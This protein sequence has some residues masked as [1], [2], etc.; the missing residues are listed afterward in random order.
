MESKENLAMHWGGP[1]K[2]QEGDPFPPLPAC[3][4]QSLT[5]P[6]EEQKEAN[7]QDSYRLKNYVKGGWK[8]WKM[9]VDR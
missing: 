9:G 7:K 8:H 5:R 6:K 1:G 3:T 4:A 2:A